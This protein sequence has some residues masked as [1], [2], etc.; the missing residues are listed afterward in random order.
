LAWP[1]IDSNT[2]YCFQQIRTAYG[3]V[4]SVQQGTG[5]IIS[6]DEINEGL[7]EP[8]EN[9]ANVAL[10]DESFANVT[11]T[12]HLSQ[13]DQESSKTDKWYLS[14]ISM[15]RGYPFDA[16]FEFEDF[17]YAPHL[18]S[19]GQYSHTS[20]PSNGNGQT[21]YVVNQGWL[22]AGQTVRSPWRNNQ[23]WG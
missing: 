13:R 5:E 16:D 8:S 18:P 1:E 9:N 4:Q 15:P 10:A 17:N 19:V 2:N 7:K 20:H 11:S 6:F 12:G 14:M 23:P 3:P 22:G 21:V